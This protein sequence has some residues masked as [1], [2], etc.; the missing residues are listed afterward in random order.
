MEDECQGLWAAAGRSTF[1]GVAT[2][3]CSLQTEGASKPLTPEQGEPKQVPQALMA[4]T[5][6]TLRQTILLHQ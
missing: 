1:P 2:R 4:A 6:K 3:W 5:E